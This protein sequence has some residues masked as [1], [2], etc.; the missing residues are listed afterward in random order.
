MAL[1]GNEARELSRKLIDTYFRTNAY[2]YT[3]HH[4]DSY[5]QFVQQDMVNIIV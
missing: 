5:D 1:T 4:I 3:R 2:P